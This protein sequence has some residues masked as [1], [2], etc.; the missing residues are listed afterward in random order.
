MTEKLEEV[1][2]GV[3]ESK[4]S[5]VIA[6]VDPDAIGAAFGLKAILEHFDV[7]PEVVYCNSLSHPQNRAI[8]NYYNLTQKML[9]LSAD[10]KIERLCLVDSQEL[11]DPRIDQKFSLESLLIAIDHHRGDLKT[12]T[13]GDECKDKFIM[14]E[15]VGS[16]STLVVELMQTL[17]VTLSEEDR[18]VY[19]LLALGIYTDT[20]DLISSTTRDHLA[21]AY[22]KKFLEIED[23]A[24]FVNYTLPSSFFRNINA[25]TRTFQQKGSRAACHLGFISL[26]DRD[27]ISSIADLFLRRE[28]VDFIAVSGIVDSEVHISFRNKNLSEPLDSFIEERFQGLGG[29]KLAPGG[30][31]EGGVRIKLDIDWWRTE[32]NSQLIVDFVKNKIDKILFDGGEE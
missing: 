4:V 32:D 26:K 17:E 16:A 24:R 6:Q 29:A 19:S 7:F 30:R 10:T 27:D 8:I 14:I 1:L 31:G 11:E 9:K 28:G 22:A 2:D 15:E 20:K 23:L 13:K 21:F 18:W 25:A 3:K 5:I 12:L